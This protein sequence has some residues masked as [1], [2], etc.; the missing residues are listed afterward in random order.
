M[1][2]QQLFRMIALALILSICFSGPSSMAQ[3]AS[4]YAGKVEKA[5]KAS[6]G[7]QMW[8][9]GYGLRDGGLGCAASVSNVLNVAGISYVRS[10]ATKYMRNQI[11][12]GSL[13][14]KEYVIKSGEEGPIDD[15]RLES[16]AKPGDVLV[17]FMDPLPRGNIGPKAHCGIM[18]PA[19]RIYTN[20]WNNGIWTHGDI[21]RYFDSYRYIRVLRFL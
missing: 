3:S 11:L 15:K 8:K 19:N 20:D 6:V 2:F 1:V 7:K 17:A 5:A 14:V 12:T 18:A 21:H 4:S 16:V 9:K 13:K 10:A